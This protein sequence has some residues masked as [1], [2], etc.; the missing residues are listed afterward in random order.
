[1]RKSSH[2]KALLA[3]AKIALG[4]STLSF[5]L[6]G[7]GDQTESLATTM[8][9]SSAG[10]D[11]RSMKPAERGATDASSPDMTSPDMSAREELGEPGSPVMANSSA[12]PSMPSEVLV[13]TSGDDVVPSVDG[14]PA[15]VASIIDGEVVDAAAPAITDEAGVSVADA[16]DS[17]SNWGACVGPTELPDRIDISPPGPSS[18][19]FECCLAEVRSALTNTPSTERSALLDQAPIADC[20]RA[21]IVAVELD[22]ELYDEPQ[23]PIAGGISPRNLCCEVGPDE[24]LFDY[25]LCT[26]WGPPVPPA[27]NWRA[28]V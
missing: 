24:T 12:A 9:V 15:A 7:C 18:S 6:L 4:S 16:G 3:T 25:R 17:G 1:M 26:P 13:P 22:D 5:G 27:M 14:G 2:R 10:D 28:A 19:E 21:M 8:S 20:C 23:T 11:A